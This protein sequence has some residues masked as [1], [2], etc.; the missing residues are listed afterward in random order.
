MFDFFKKAPIKTLDDF[1]DKDNGLLTQ[2]GGWIGGLQYTNQEQAEDYKAL[3]KG[4]T[5]Y[6]VATLSENTERSRTRR[7][8]AVLWIKAQ[9]GLVLMAALAAPWSDTLFARYWKMA[10]SEV[11]G[12]GTAGVM[13]FFFGSY[14]IGTHIIGRLSDKSNKK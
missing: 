1:T 3:V 8:I 10:S 12:Y 6:A 2:V 9:L 7:D 4:V 11:M 13:L 14:G 5:D